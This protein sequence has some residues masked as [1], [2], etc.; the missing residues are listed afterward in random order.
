MRWHACL[1][2]SLAHAS[3]LVVLLRAGEA[4][5]AAGRAAE[6]EAEL[7]QQKELVARLEEDLLAADSAGGAAGA[8]GGAAAGAGEAGSAD[9]GGGAEGGGEQT[10]VAVLCSQRDRFRAR[11]QELE[12]HLATLGQELK[13]VGCPL[14]RWRRSQQ[15]SGAGA[16]CQRLNMC[17]AAAASAA[18]GLLGSTRAV[19]ASCQAGDL[20]SPG[21]YAVPAAHCRCGQMRRR[22]VPT[23]WRWQSGSSLCRQAC[24]G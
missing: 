3:C 17:A 1:T 21:T 9:G 13:K 7:A 15:G 18:S 11:A 4:E 16:C 5:S 14:C 8:A 23:T 22:C 19:L 24:G 6:L 20:P 12:S 10:M 2:A